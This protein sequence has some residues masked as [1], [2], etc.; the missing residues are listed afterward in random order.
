LGPTILKGCVTKGDPLFKLTE[1]ELEVLIVE[2]TSKIRT[3]IIRRCV[4]TDWKHMN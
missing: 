1:K 2:R 4:Y 3:E